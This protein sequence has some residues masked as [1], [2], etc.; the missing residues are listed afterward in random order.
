MNLTNKVDLKNQVVRVLIFRRLY[1]KNQERIILT[2]S[3]YLEKQLT[4]EDI[5]KYLKRISILIRR[6]EVRRTEEKTILEYERISEKV[7]RI[8]WG[9]K[10]DSIKLNE[11]NRK[12][13]KYFKYEKMSYI[14]RFCRS[15]ENLSKEKRDTLVVFKESE[16][17]NVLE[18]K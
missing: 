18:K 8:T 2:N 7:S 6:N 10:E 12:K 14:Q 1:Y 4:K 5:E 13:R 16:N 3:L 11:L 9:H 17:E 15:K